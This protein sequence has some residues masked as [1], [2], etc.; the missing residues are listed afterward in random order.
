[1]KEKPN[2]WG[3]GARGNHQGGFTIME[4]LVV[5][6]VTAILAGMATSAS[7]SWRRQAD[8]RAFLTQ[9]QNHLAI[10]RINTLSKRIPTQLVIDSDSSYKLQ[11]LT[12]STWGSDK[13]YS[14]TPG[15]IIDLAKT[16]GRTYRF[17][18]SGYITVLDASGNNTSDS[19][20]HGKGDSKDIIDVTA[21]GTSRFRR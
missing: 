1:M 10:S 17:A 4:L 14:Y 19:S 21:L 9:L 12:G 20:I 13:S 15:K 7:A 16:K 3:S 6:M 11:T 5:V 18:S 2:R 8:A